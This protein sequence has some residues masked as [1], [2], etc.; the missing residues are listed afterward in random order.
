MKQWG[1]GA[2]RAKLRPVRWETELEQSAD[3]K[4]EANQR[5][6]ALLEAEE[7]ATAAAAEKEWMN[8]KLKKGKMILVM[9]QC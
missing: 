7:E 6:A 1:E 8:Y 4:N 5:A 9:P 2:M 3:M